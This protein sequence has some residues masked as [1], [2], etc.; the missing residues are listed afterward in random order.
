MATP[1]PQCRRGFS[2]YLVN[3]QSKIDLFFDQA[4]QQLGKTPG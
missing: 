4:A 2:L 3:W 1:N